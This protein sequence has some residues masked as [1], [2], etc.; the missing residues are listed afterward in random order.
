MKNTFI[1]IV[2]LA[3]IGVGAYFVLV[4]KNQP[5]EEMNNMESVLPT[6]SSSE[7]PSES[8]TMSPASSSMEMS[9]VKEFSII[10]TSFKFSVPEIRV[11]KGD[12][13]RIVLKNEGGF[14]D[15]VVDE[16]NARTK[17]ISS[18]QTDT[19]EFLADKTG[20]FEY[21]CSVMQHR[22]MGMVGKLIVE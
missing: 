17:Q 7:S 20:T 18:G 13:I 15:W 10:A 8:P 5:A 14:H 9:Q 6:I 11:K 19:I 21:Y 2:V 22:K 12:T 16:F 3:V 4:K 1:I